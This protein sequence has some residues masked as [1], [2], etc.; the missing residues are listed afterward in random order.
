L[1]KGGRPVDLNELRKMTLPKLRELAKEVTSLQGV[2]GMKKEELVEA[3]AK[4]KGL[5]FKPA[6]KDLQS[7]GAVK[8]Q[9]RT[10]KKQRQEILASSGDRLKLKRLRR[11]IKLLKRQTRR[12]A[13]ITKSEALKPAAGESPS[14]PPSNASA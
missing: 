7:I 2:L 11:K 10:L 14:T 12:S 6:A 9:I 13:A 3:I 1:S 4:V 5:S 8:Q